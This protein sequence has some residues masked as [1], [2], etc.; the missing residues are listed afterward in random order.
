MLW[1]ILAFSASLLFAVSNF[2]DRFLIEKRIKDPFFISILGGFVTLAV[3]VIIFV[4][5]GFPAIPM[6]QVLILLLAGFLLEVAL[7]PWYKAIA[8]DDPSHVVPYFQLIPVAI[9]VQAYF[10]L[11]ERPTLDQIIGS[12]FIVFGGLLL[13]VSKL[14]KETFRFRKSFWY[15]LT[16]ILFFSLSSVLF[17]FVVIEQDFW[18]TVAYEF[19]GSGIGGLFLLIFFSSGFIGSVKEVGVSTWKIVGV[20][21]VVYFAGRTCLLYATALGSVYLVSVLGGTQPFF[22]FAIGLA[23]SL[24]FP[25]VVKEDISKRTLIYKLTAIAIMFAGIIFINR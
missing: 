3:G 13:S 4:L 10:I 5:K 20:N 15:I 22:V 12:A 24:W 16:A 11:G 23:L 6:N 17:K 7:V 21:E 14:S 2:I 1:I 18:S 19:F 8:L 25:E 9:F